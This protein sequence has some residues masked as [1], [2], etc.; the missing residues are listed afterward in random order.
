MVL[1]VMFVVGIIALAILLFLGSLAISP[2][3]ER[4]PASGSLVSGSSAS[5]AELM[6]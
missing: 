5:D 2:E 4:Y 3:A 1:S 6:Q